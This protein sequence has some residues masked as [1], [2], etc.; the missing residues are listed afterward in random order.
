MEVIPAVDIRGG[1]CVRLR[2]GDYDRETIF[3]E[4]PVAVA[5]HWQREGAQMVHVVDLDG[6]REGR[7]VN[8]SIILRMIQEGVPVQVGGGIRTEENVRMLIEAGAQRVVLGTAA[9]EAPDLR[10]RLLACYPE[11]VVLGIDCRSGRVAV[12]GWRRQLP[13]TLEDF[14]DSIVAEGA[15]RV[16][17]T[18][19]GR[20]G[21][22]AG[23]NLSLLR[24]ALTRDVQV[25]ASGGVGSLDHLHAL[26]D[27]SREHANLEGVIV[28][29]ALYDGAF[30]LA[31]AFEAVLDLGGEQ[32]C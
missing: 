6:A 31:K 20:D 4:D 24:Q 10:A 23:P 19:I 1:R 29:R 13:L 15:R 5:Q 32:S 18:D 14:I 3:D 21:M 26:Y 25:I 9:V 7:Q 16:I 27:L 30:P 12:G 8:A 2:Q 28:G 22:L 11:Q 17:V